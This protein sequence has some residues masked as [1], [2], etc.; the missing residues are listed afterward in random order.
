LY[1]CI[2]VEANSV[3]SWNP[4][5]RIHKWQIT[6]AAAASMMQGI[7]SANEISNDRSGY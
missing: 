4:A 2:V 1:D 5:W 3:C 7:S 6:K